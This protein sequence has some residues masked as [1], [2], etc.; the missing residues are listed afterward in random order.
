MNMYI[1]NDVIKMTKIGR[2]TIC[3]RNCGQTDAGTHAHARTHA[4]THTHTHTHTHT[5]QPAQ[6]QH[7]ISKGYRKVFS[8][9]FFS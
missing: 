9:F 3:P 4:R 8:S 1:K 6:Q 2:R 7:A 5:I